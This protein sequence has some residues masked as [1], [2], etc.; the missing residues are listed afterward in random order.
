M[1]ASCFVALL[2][3]LLVGIFEAVPAGHL[4]SWVNTVLAI[5]AVGGLAY[6]FLRVPFLAVSIGRNRSR[7]RAVKAHQR[8][9]AEWAKSRQ[10]DSKRIMDEPDGERGASVL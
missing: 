7:W 4:P 1:L 8:E 3:R 5:L 6:F 9:L 10:G 2:L